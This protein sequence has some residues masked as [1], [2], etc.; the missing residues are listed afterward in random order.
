MLP[1]L[2]ARNFLYFFTC[3]WKRA[4][5]TTCSE[6]WGCS[7]CECVPEVA[8]YPKGELFAYADNALQPP[9]PRAKHCAQRIFEKVFLRLLHGKADRRGGGW[10]RRAFVLQGKSKSHYLLA[11]IIYARA[12]HTSRISGKTQ[13]AKNMSHFITVY[14]W[15]SYMLPGK[16]IFLLHKQPFLLPFHVHSMQTEEEGEFFLYARIFLLQAI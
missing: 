10:G 13:L 5:Q 2:K 12:F 16:C 14:V 8:N 6:N 9:K 1:N 3:A 15:R 4:D 7:T 11:A